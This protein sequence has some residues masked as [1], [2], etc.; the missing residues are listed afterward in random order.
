MSFL[1]N[2][3]ICSVVALVCVAFV[4]V[5][6][7]Q[8]QDWK[9][10]GRLAGKVLDEE[11]NP[12]PGAQ[13]K[14]ELAG[15][16]GPEEPLETDKKGKWA[17][18]GL[19]GGR[20][21]IDIVAEGYVPRR[22]VATISQTSRLPPM[23]IQMEKAQPVGPPPEV[24][25]AIEKGDTAYKEGRYAEARVEYERLLELRPDLGSTLHLQI[26]RCYKGEGNVEKELEFLDSVLAEDPDNADVRTLMAME[27]IEGGMLERGLELLAQIDATTVTDPDI[28][29][30]I[31][32]SFLNKSRPEE[33]VTYF[34]KAVDLA[35]DYVDGYFQRALTQ[36]G[37]Q[38]YEECRVDFEKV[39]ELSPEGPKAET[40]KKVLEQLP[41]EGQE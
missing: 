23:K 3:I 26:A 5:T 21:N 9:G 7:G 32:V 20:W 12:V 2:V 41:A 4:A 39:L 35:P 24:L 1:K 14:L 17:I 13:V 36:F 38:K 11:G 33:A 28:Y 15:R 27:A 40:A 34:T 10:Q 31:G 8:A 37:A 16:G 6:P 25:E 22:L 29:Y 19:A 18:F 30:N